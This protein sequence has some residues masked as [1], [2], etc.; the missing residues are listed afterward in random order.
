MGYLK[1]LMQLVGIKETAERVL[2][3]HAA[4]SSSPRMVSQAHGPGG[5]GPNIS[6]G[7]VAVGGPHVDPK[8]CSRAAPPPR[9]SRLRDRRPTITPIV[10]GPLV[11]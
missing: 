5:R 10:G 3:L 1:V 8:D 6:M 7:T 4:G 11:S 2:A 9:N